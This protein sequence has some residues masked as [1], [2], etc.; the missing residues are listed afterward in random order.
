MNKILF[1]AFMLIACLTGCAVNPVT[2]ENQLSLISEAQEIEIGK[3]NYAPLRQAQGGD[4]VVD[5]Q[6]TA[7]VSEVG[8]KLAAVSD[9]KLPYEFK[10]L[11]SSVPNAWALPGG[12][13]SLNRGLLVE[14]ESEA[15][16]AAVLGHE[17]THAAAKHTVS[18]MS[19]GMLIQGAVLATVVG[20]QDKEYAQLAAL[21]AGIGAQL[22]TQK[23]G[24]DA[25]R[26]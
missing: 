15:E 13:I 11:N 3:K 14:L 26:E 16:L 10:V 24:R 2:G 8:Q 17:I 18:S 21:G 19:R 25:E 12:K 9:R 20:T 22:V 23:Y 7:Y 4:Y 6:L 5:K 1:I